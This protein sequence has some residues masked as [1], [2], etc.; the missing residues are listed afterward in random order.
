MHNNMISTTSYGLRVR[1]IALA[2]A[3]PPL[4]RGCADAGRVGSVPV[5]VDV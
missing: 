3:V 5:S 1:A 2:E 4:A